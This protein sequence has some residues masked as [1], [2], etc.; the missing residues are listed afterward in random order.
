[1]KAS[2][3]EVSVGWWYSVCCEE[4]LDQIKTEEEL[5]E[6]REYD[7]E[8][9]ADPDGAML[10]YN[11]WPTLDA[12]LDALNDGWTPEQREAIRAAKSSGR[13]I[14]RDVALNVKP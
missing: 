10:T 13:D 4:D 1:M 7:R 9:E 2:A 6:M 8:E 11:C 3:P 12:A 5:A 14:P